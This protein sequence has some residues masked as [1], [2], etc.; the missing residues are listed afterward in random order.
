MIKTLLFLEGDCSSKATSLSQTSIPGCSSSSSNFHCVHKNERNKHL[1]LI[2][3]SSMNSSFLSSGSGDS[4]ESTNFIP[5]QKS[6]QNEVG[7]LN[8]KLYNIN[9]SSSSAG[10]SFLGK[11][12]F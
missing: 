3:Q 9:S 5:R 4:W 7:R 1:I 2:R 10:S 8:P 11:M 6:K 12:P